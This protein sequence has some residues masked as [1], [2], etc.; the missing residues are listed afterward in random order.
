M[1]QARSLWSWLGAY[2]AGS[3]P[4]KLGSELRELVSEPMEPVNH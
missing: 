1:E 3:E 4:K 2:G